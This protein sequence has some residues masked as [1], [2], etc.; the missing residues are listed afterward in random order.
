MVHFMLYEFH[1]LKKKNDPFKKGYYVT[2]GWKVSFETYQAG[3]YN[4]V[5]WNV[6]LCLIKKPFTMKTTV[7]RTRNTDQNFLNL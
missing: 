2:V 5:S 6:T 4:Q 1:I 3:P 7:S